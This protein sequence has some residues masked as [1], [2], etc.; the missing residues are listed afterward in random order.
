M[1][2]TQATGCIC[3]QAQARLLPVAKSW[4]RACAS[5]PAGPAPL[6]SPNYTPTASASLSLGGLGVADMQ[7]SVSHPGPPSHILPGSS[8]PGR[9]A[10]RPRPHPRLTRSPARPWQMGVRRWASAYSVPG[11]M[12]G[13]LQ[14]SLTV[15]TTL[16]ARY[17][18]QAYLRGDDAE[19]RREDA[20]FVW[21]S[22]DLSRLWPFPVQTGLA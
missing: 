20:Q 22:R 8:R 4:P 16:S 7:G 19:A 10:I 13:S 9:G 17:H 6:R 21:W 11:P 14:M 18:Q 12:L 2:N 3:L 5:L 1:A 15:S